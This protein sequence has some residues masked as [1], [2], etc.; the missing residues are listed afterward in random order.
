[1]LW[2]SNDGSILT[3][4]N[5]TNTIIFAGSGSTQSYRFNTMDF[6]KARI[7][8]LV[9][10]GQLEFSQTGDRAFALTGTGSAST[11]TTTLAKGAAPAHNYVVEGDQILHSR[12]YVSNP[13]VT[14]AAPSIIAG[15][16]S[17]EGAVT[18]R[19]GSIYQRSDGGVGTSLYVKES[20]TGNTGWAAK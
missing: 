6:I 9:D 12:L 3:D 4:L 5:G 14:S 1:M 8:N 18:A 20:G 16:G 11:F 2:L 17:P 15:A 13:T 19:I 10:T 7:L